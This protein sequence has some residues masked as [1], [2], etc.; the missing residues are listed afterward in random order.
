MARVVN[1]M[2]LNVRHDQHPH[3]IKHTFAEPPERDSPFDPAQFA[4]EQPWSIR[5]W[6]IV[7]TI[8]LYSPDILGLQVNN[9]CVFIVN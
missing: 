4:F 6:K 1:F 8:L 2:S 9:N 7:D 5:K 3:S